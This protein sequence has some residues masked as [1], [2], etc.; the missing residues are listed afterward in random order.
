MSDTNTTRVIDLDAIKA[1]GLNSNDV[2]MRMLAEHRH[3]QRVEV[4]AEMCCKFIADNP[5]STDL[6][7]QQYRQQTAAELGI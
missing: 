5:Q 1:A 7:L 2:S 4:L 6:E 3:Q